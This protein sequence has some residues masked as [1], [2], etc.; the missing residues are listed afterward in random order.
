MPGGLCP[1]P[2]MCVPPVLVALGVS[3]T[4]D[5]TMAG[6]VAMAGAVTPSEPPHPPPHISYS[7]QEKPEN[8][9]E[10]SFQTDF[11]NSQELFLLS[12]RLCL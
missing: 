3:V 1:P 2:G 12:T 8:W 10:F 5:V 11:L 9:L 6:D 4:G 7:A